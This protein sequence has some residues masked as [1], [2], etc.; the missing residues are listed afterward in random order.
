MGIDQ[1]GAR[2]WV[3]AVELVEVSAVGVMVVVVVVVV[4]QALPG[5]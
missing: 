5:A 1:A 4:G 3:V 2:S